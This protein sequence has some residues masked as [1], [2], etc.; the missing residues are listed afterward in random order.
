MTHEILTAKTTSAENVLEEICSCLPEGV[1]IPK[2]R[3]AIIRAFVGQW[4][5]FPQRLIH[6]ERNREMLERFFNGEAKGRLCREYQISRSQFHRIVKSF[7]LQAKI[8]A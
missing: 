7:H 3:Q 5:Y 2:I 1:E 6:A 8:V 4:V